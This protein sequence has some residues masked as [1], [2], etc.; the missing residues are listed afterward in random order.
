MVILIE[1]WRMPIGNA[2]EGDDE[3][4]SRKLTCGGWRRG[5]DALDE[6]GSGG[7]VDGGV[8]V[9]WGNGGILWWCGVAGG[10]EPS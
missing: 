10:E 3:I 4:H 8:A 6:V 7:L 2:G 1:R 5:G 9:L